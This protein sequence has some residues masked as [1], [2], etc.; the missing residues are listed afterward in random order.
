M[1]ALNDWGHYQTC[2]LVLAP[3]FSLASSFE[4]LFTAW[5]VRCAHSIL[6][7]HSFF[8]TFAFGFASGLSSNEG[9]VLEKAFLERLEMCVR[10]FSPKIG[11]AGVGFQA[12]VVPRGRR[13][14]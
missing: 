5:A 1:H 4:I 6:S 10:F 2:P 7:V 3:L 12:L 9:G 13:V 11:G 8:A 14:R